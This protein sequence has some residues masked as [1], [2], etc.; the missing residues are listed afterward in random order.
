MR[1][2]DDRLCWKDA[3]RLA[4]LDGRLVLVLSGDIC[5]DDASPFPFDFGLIDGESTGAE[6]VPVLMERRDGASAINPFGNGY[7]GADG[8]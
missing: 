1:G 7:T 3:P 2:N 6:D 8:E 4:Y 5:G